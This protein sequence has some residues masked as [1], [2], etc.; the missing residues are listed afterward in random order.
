MKISIVLIYL[1]F[2]T[3]SLSAQFEFAERIEIGVE[4]KLGDYF[5]EDIYLFDQNGD[6][7]HLRSIIDKP[8][9]ISFVYYRCPGICSPLM[10]GIADVIRKSDMEIGK[11]YQVFTISF[12]VRE[13]PELAKRKKI[14]YLTQVQKPEAAN[15]WFFFTGDSINI[16]K[17]TD[18]AGFRYIQTG[19]DFQHT[20]GLILSSPDGKITR[21]LNGT[22]FLPFELKMAVVEASKGQPSPTI[23]RILQLCYS[24]DPKSQ[25]YVLNIKQISGILIIFVTTAI[26][27]ILV[28]KPL[29]KR[30]IITNNQ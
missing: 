25:Q 9:V 10:N 26:F 5:P 21:Y 12:D 17:I 4:E 2:L 6:T 8:T 15:G 27:L 22:T 24:Y 16:A 13:P 11:D 20:A 3:G 29:F 19:N 7:V 23:N 28:L 14:N 1:F 18:A 30:K